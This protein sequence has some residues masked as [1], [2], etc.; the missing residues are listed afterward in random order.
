MET[1]SVFNISS[2]PYT[3]W[4][5]NSID[6]RTPTPTGA[7]YQGRSGNAASTATATGSRSA[8]ETGSAKGGA[9]RVVDVG[10]GRDWLLWG[11]MGGAILVGG[12]AMFV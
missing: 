6:T 5:P 4:L 8:G 1:G 7:T 3:T 12:V 11:S 10:S 2:A 9:G